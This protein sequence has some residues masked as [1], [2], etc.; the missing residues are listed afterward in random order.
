MENNSSLGFGNALKVN[1]MD[2]S[3]IIIVGNTGFSLF[4]Y[5]L[6]LMQKLVKSVGNL[7][8]VANNEAD[9]PE[10]FSKEGIKFISMPIDHKGM[11]PVK[12]I[13]L[14]LKLLIFY[15]R[16]KP[17]VVH[18]FTIKP[19]IMGTLAAK[20]AGVKGI[21]NTITGLG[22]AFEKKNLLQKLVINLYRFT[23]K[24]NVQIIFQNKDNRDYFI[25]KGICNSSQA[26]IV[27][28]SG[29][30]TDKYYP[31]KN[32]SFDNKK[33]V[34]FLATRMLW[35]KGI[36]EFVE[37]AQSIRAVYS[38]ATFIMAGGASGGGAAANPQAIPIKW[39]EEV[40]N[41]SCVKWLGR[42]SFGQVMELLKG[43]YAIVFPSYHEGLPRFLIEAGSL[44][45]PL[46][47]F[48]VPGCREVVQNGANGYLVK[49]KNGE[50]LAKAVF[51]LLD[52]PKKAEIMGEKAREQTVRYYDDSEIYKKTLEVYTSAGMEAI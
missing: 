6:S 14:I 42:I 28:G 7:I 47:A 10:K 41:G 25:K 3:K 9:Y 21:V 16:E 33:P 22:Y 40:N 18:H 27:E 31:D 15:R 11:N 1:Q 20:L 49:N 4:N 2:K 29:L 5:R 39:L 34:F 45:K 50:E 37:M 52:D 8:A 12:D 30:N 19:V 38:N 43:S 48:D 36:A 23:M 26:H 44:A 35:S 46:I 17:D 32:F 13:L 24:G 51:K